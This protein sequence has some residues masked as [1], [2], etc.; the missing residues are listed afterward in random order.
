MRIAIH[1][2]LHPL[3]FA[4]EALVRI[5]LVHQEGEPHKQSTQQQ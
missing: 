1:R 2:S 4:Q 3:R 5:R